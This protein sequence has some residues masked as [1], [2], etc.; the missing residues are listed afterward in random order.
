MRERIAFFVGWVDSQQDDCFHA[1]S[2]QERAH[3]NVNIQG[4]LW[5]SKARDL[6]RRQRRPFGTRRHDAKKDRNGGRENGGPSLSR[7]D[8]FGGRLEARSKKGWRAAR[9]M[10]PPPLYP[11]LEKEG[12]LIFWI[13]H[14][15]RSYEFFGDSPASPEGGRVCS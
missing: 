6:N 5:N 9:M 12:R 8:P 11:L 1:C 7:R 4:S 13:G 15:F 3:R 10:S 2:I 14:S